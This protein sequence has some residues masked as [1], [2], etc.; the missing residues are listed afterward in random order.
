MILIWA[1]ALA[2]F[3]S[4]GLVVF[5]GAPYVPS[6]R[7][8]VEKALSELYPLSSEDT[9]VDFGSGDGLVL[10][11][12]ARRGARAIGYEM[13]PFLVAIARLLSRAEPRVKVHLADAWAVSWPAETTVVYAFAVTR[14]MP[15]LLA[16]LQQH[17]TTTQ[18]PLLF[19]SYGT[20]PLGPEMVATLGAHGLY[21]ITPLQPSQP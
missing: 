12:A 15:R 8:E 1:L 10:R 3:I 18:R 2:I 17:A 21:R 16:K 5:R 14:D 20:Q 19:I 4:F 6:H 13:N 7:K 11:A 9:L